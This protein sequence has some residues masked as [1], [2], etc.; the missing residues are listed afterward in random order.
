MLQKLHL[1]I[2]LLLISTLIVGNWAN[3][4]RVD[5]LI[6]SPPV[7]L[8]L[9]I[10]SEFEESIPVFSRDSSKLYFIRTYHPEN[11]GGA[12]GDQ[13]IW[14]SQLD[15]EGNWSPAKNLSSLNNKENNGVFGINESETT[16]YLLNAYLKKKNH[17]EKGVAIADRRGNEWE[18]KPQTLP[19]PNLKIE[20]DFY[21]FHVNSKETVLLISNRGVGTLGEEDLYVSIK[22]SSGNWG[23]PIHLGPQINTKGYEMSPYLTPG[24]DTLYF[25]SDGHEGYGEADIFYSVRKGKGWQDWTQPKNLGPSINSKLFDAYFIRSNNE[26]YWSSNRTGS[27][28]DIYTAKVTSHVWPLLPEEKDTVF[29]ETPPNTTFVISTADMF[30]GEEVR[31][32]SNDTLFMKIPQDSI[33]IVRATVDTNYSAPGRV[34]T[35]FVEVPTGEP[36]IDT[37]IVE[38]PSGEPRIDTVIVE[39]PTGEPRIDTVIVEVPTGEPR[40][41]TVYINEPGSNSTAFLDIIIYFDL[42]KWFLT[43]D[44]R[45]LLNKAIAIMNA[46]PNFH[47]RLE[48][49][50]DIRDTDN[51]N[52]WLS[53]KRIESAKKYLADG[54]IDPNKFNGGYY[55]ETELAVFTPNN[56]SPEDDHHQNRRVTLTFGTPEDIKKIELE[57]KM[58]DIEKSSKHGFEIATTNKGTR[59]NKK[60]ET[61]TANIEGLEYKVQ[62]FASSRN[63]DPS[64]G[65][66]KGLPE[67]SVYK[68]SG[69]YKVT[70]GSFKTKEDADQHLRNCRN[71]GYQ[72]AFIV[73][74]KDGKRI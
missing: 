4:Q 6:F 17:F 15:S 1:R 58:P 11:V 37:V 49:H 8:S 14:V 2:L 24:L 22:D 54:G 62:V 9:S 47:V 3:A 52:M 27:L 43:F 38:V 67:V 57:H 68:Q 66:F 59:K 19:I 53:E 60:A 26:V 64:I 42:D 33:F 13:D 46:N 40:I 71:L 25:S 28:S 31:K 29:I 18:T 7:A 41:D 39:V 74:F 61:N 72:G 63:V 51:Y 23:S 20:G 32:Q 50:T 10:N 5:S 73:N 21:G 44:S 69:H 34:D 48:G 65:K 35:V 55:G 45:M 56:M 12:E 70:T 30:A 36:R 16:I